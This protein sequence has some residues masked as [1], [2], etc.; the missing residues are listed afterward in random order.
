MGVVDDGTIH[1]TPPIR[2]KP[3][4]PALPRGY[5]RPYY[6][7]GELI[8]LTLSSRTGTPPMFSTKSTT[9]KDPK[10]SVRWLKDCTF[11]S[12][13]KDPFDRDEPTVYY[14]GPYGLAYIWLKWLSP[15]E[16]EFIGA[17]PDIEEQAAK[18]KETKPRTI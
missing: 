5:A 17:P 14:R 8:P 9:G 16:R 6:G 3:H 1:N 11:E 12:L 4:R 7:V 18:L 2:I 15:E 10:A 13:K